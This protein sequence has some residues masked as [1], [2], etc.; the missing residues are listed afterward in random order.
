MG[1]PLY[2]YGDS[3]LLTLYFDLFYQSEPKFFNIS[4]VIPVLE[5]KFSS[6]AGA[7]PSVQLN[8]ISPQEFADMYNQSNALAADHPHF[9]KFSTDQRAPHNFSLTFDAVKIEIYDYKNGQQGS[10]I[11]S[12]TFQITVY[13]LFSIYNEKLSMSGLTSKVTGGSGGDKPLVKKILDGYLLPGFAKRVQAVELPQFQDIFGTQLRAEIAN[14]RIVEDLFYIYLTIDRSSAAEIDLGKGFDTEAQQLEKSSVDSAVL[15]AAV[16]SGAVNTVVNALYSPITHSFKEKK[17]GSFG[18]AG[19][20]G[21]FTMGKPFITII[22]S[23]ASASARVYMDVKGGIKLFWDWTW[24]SLPVPTSIVNISLSLTQSAD[25]KTGFI[26]LTGVNDIKVNIG[27]WPSI[28]KPIRKII[29]D[30]LNRIANSFK[31]IIN[32][33]LSGTQIELFTLPGEIPGTNIKAN[34]SFDRLA[35]MNSGV[36]ALTRISK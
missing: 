25:R 36:Q 3:N 19:V 17:S 33:A 15:T 29:D 5:A 31:G 13:G 21:S 12:E 23:S 22:G 8:P 18:G 32:R 27:G 34:L 28:L 11:V 2:A 35:F 24:V 9:L 26:R 7:A 30:L 4:Q 14:V 6:L 10:L 1:Y 16:T 20:K